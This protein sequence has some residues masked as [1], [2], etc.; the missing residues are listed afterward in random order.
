[1]MSACTLLKLLFVCI[2]LIF[3]FIVVVVVAVVAVV[4]VNFHAVDSSLT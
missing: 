4:V 2:G 1:M 3:F